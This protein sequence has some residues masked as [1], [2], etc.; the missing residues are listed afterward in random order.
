MRRGQPALPPTIKVV[1]VP[2]KEGLQDT[3]L[4]THGML[5]SVVERSGCRLLVLVPNSPSAEVRHE[6]EATAS[7]YLSNEPM[8]RF[9]RLQCPLRNIHQP[10][11]T[12]TKLDARGTDI[13]Y[14][15]SFLVP[16][17]G[18]VPEEAGA[19]R[20]YELKSIALVVDEPG[21]LPLRA[22]FA[23]LGVADSERAGAG[24]PCSLIVRLA[25]MSPHA[26]SAMP[27]QSC[28][29]KRRLHA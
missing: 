6:K 1:I 29:K 12:V 5:T 11:T 19:Q 4:Q 15:V 2:S 13:F 16:V 18:L 25:A 22:M 8:S 23:W 10:N 7:P 9:S 24:S 28:M 17:A 27:A 21:E 26:P 20:T 14:H 3:A